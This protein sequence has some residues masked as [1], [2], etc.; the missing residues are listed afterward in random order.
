MIFR[1]L[2]EGRA[3]LMRSGLQ[4]RGPPLARTRN[5]R[6]LATTGAASK[7]AFKFAP[8]TSLANVHGSKGEDNNNEER[9]GCVTATVGGATMRVTAAGAKPSDDEKEALHAPH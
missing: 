4:Q 2:R 1:S 8:T 7:N 9:S 5:P 6:G 3:R